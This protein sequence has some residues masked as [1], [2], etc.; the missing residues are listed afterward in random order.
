MPA[1]G[2]VAASI[3]RVRTITVEFCPLSLALALDFAMDN[4]FEFPTVGLQTAVT[5]SPSSGLPAGIDDGFGWASLSLGSSS[6]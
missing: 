2:F 5:S 6:S 4:Q 3:S 1:H